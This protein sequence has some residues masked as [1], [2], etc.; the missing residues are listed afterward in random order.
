MSKKESNMEFFKQMFGGSWITQGIWVAAE[1]GIADLLV[2]GPQTVQELA[3]KT[4][5]QRGSLYRL[6]RALASV[7]IFTEEKN[8]QFSLTSRADMLRSDIDGSQRSFA[9][10]MGAEFH[11][12]W[13]ELLYSVR[14]GKPG[15]HKHF[16]I[17][18]FQYMTENPNRHSIYDAAMTG[19]HGVETEPMLDACDFGTFRTVVD[20]GGGNGLVLAAIL[21]RHP[22]TQGILFDLPPVADR[23]RSI[24]SS[25]GLS[26]R[27]QIVGGDFF[28]SVPN[29]A[30]AYV[31]RHIIHD[32]E[33]NDA[34]AILR[35]CQ[36]AMS[37]DGKILVVEIVIPPLNEP[38]FGKW[39]DLMMLLVAGR[40]RTQE[41][42]SDLFSEA[43]LKLNRV[44]PTSSEVSI[45]EGIRA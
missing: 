28:S 19:V 10:M 25:L 31:L 45:I 8:G 9:I 26:D 6:M 34:I 42:Y 7:G 15:F 43:G 3:K 33:D 20:I 29:G 27:C 18:F 11:A 39:L 22:R 13:G 40:E 23:A 14:T 2:D 38:S 4:Q 36:E 21:N 44:I 37:S 16:G 5:T 17:P 30:N 32:W 35:Q 12:A 41:E 24:I 1:L